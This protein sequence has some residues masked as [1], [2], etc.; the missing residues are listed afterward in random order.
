[1]A[2]S[3]TRIAFLFGTSLLATL[4]YVSVS[5]QVRRRETGKLDRK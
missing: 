2:S 4:G 1:M 5:E 3:T